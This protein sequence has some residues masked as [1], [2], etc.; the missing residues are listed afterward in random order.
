MCPL[1]IISFLHDFL[2]SFNTVNFFPT[3]FKYLHSTWFL[4]CGISIIVVNRL[5]VLQ[6]HILPNTTLEFVNNSASGF[7]GAVA[8]DNFRGVNDTTLVLNNMCFIQYN[9]GSKDEY[10]PSNWNVS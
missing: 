10:E 9:I 2:Q 5:F 7:G 4:D 1:V 3:C 6:M 8:V